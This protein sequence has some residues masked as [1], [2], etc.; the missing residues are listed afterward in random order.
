MEA[1]NYILLALISIIGY[2]LRDLHSRL[3]DT[4]SDK[5]DIHD[6]VVRIESKVQ[7]LDEKMPSEIANLEKVMD[8]KF[9]QF[10]DKFEELTKA[11]RHAEKTMTNQANAFVELLK[12]YRK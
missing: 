12:E 1:P 4:I 9:E 7:R 10:N 3:K 11:I 2:F 6:K 8:L 5:D